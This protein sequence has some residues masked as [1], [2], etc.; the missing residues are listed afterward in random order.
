MRALTVA[1]FFAITFNVYGQIP[2]Y[3]P[4]E[5]LVAWYPFN[6]NSN[7]ESGNTNDAVNT[8]A[9]LTSDRFGSVDS[10]YHLQN[11]NDQIAAT[12]YAPAFNNQ[13][14][15]ISLWVRLP[16]QF[17]YSSLALVKNGVPYSNGFD[18]FIDQ[19]DAAYGPNNYLVGYLVGS[20]QAV[21][22]ITNHSELGQWVNIVSTYDG[23]S[24]KIFMNAVLRS[25][26]AFSA[27]LNSP[28]ND[29]LFSFW[30][31]ASA[32]VVTE[33]MID[34]IG[35]WNRALTEVEIEALYTAE[36]PISGCTDET[37]CNFN[38]NAVEADGSCE[39]G[40]NDCGTIQINSPS[41]VISCAD[42]VWLEASS[43]SG[44]SWNGTVVSDSIWVNSSGMYTVQ[45]S[46]ETG[47]IHLGGDLE[48]LELGDGFNNLEFPISVITRFKLPLGFE[49][50]TL[51]A[52]DEGLGYSGIWV[53][54]GLGQ[55]ET[56]IGD[57][58]GGGPG[59]RRS[60]NASFDFEL[61]TWY[62]LVVVIRGA[63]DHSI[64]IDGVD[65]GGSY[66]GYGNG[67][68]VDLGRPA[69]I[70]YVVP[71]SGPGVG[72]DYAAPLVIDYLGVFSSDILNNENAMEFGMCHVTNTLSDAAMGWYEFSLESPLAETTGNQGEINSIGGFELS[73]SQCFCPA[74]DTV[75]VTLTDCNSLSQLCGEGTVWDSETQECVVAYPSDSNFDSC[76]DLNDLM[77]L[78]S[79]YGICLVPA[80]TCV[81]DIEHDG[82]D[83]STVQIGDQCW[84]SE[85]CRYL[86]EVSPESYS[87]TTDPDYYV[88]GYEGIDVAAAQ[89]TTNF[90]TYGVLY[91]WP[92]VMTAGICPSGWHIPS[93]GEFT[94]LTNFIGSENIAGEEMKSTSGWSN[95]GNGSNSSGWTGL[96]GG[97]RYSGGF[98][99]NGN[100]GVWWSASESGSYSWER[101]LVHNFVNVFRNVNVRSYGFS[102]RCVRD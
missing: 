26:L 20:G 10:A 28:N 32:P 23:A 94:Q 7:D 88:Y 91:N 73:E 25:S 58:F 60:K 76:V 51:F 79:S 19:N 29:L 75:L 30:D 6:G 64:L 78:L 37:A 70:G 67:L 45:K 89:A 14:Q 48:W 49:Y 43:S 81:D 83:Y 92:A 8:G 17:T 57:G 9:I 95:N 27:S 77:D 22:F 38:E 31:N 54:L 16:N 65:V 33:R 96:P 50:G 87:S 47:A 90:E 24:I 34:D 3:V 86:P 63:T 102:A 101:E 40:C 71:D 46:I 13:A 5:G 97:Y 68:L 66:S 69:T 84:F 36:I 74:S 35:I 39:Y 18:V 62:E 52:T 44:V 85:N 59:Q 72:I 56:S 80:F 93:D 100:Y 12:N 2:D 21:T 99:D 41:H 4:T 55:V 15:S 53:G 1:L 82:Y 61:E 11:L 98:R 42:G